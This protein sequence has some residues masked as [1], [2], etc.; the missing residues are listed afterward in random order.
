M[1]MNPKDFGKYRL[2]LK[3]SHSMP[4]EAQHYAHMEA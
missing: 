3:K 4:L 1:L 2:T